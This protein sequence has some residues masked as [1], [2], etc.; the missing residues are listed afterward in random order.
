MGQNLIILG[1]PLLIVLW[2]YFREHQ[3]KNFCHP[4]ADFGQGGGVIECTKKEK[5]VKKIFF[6][7][8][9]N[10]EVLKICEK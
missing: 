2:K 3:Q 7:I 10:D 6:Q 9:L 1:D 5:F 8:M 4:L